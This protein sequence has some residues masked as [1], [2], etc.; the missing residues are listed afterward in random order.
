MNGPRPA[1]VAGCERLRTKVTEQLAL[2]PLVATSHP[3]V[4]PRPNLTHHQTQPIDLQAGG[5]SRQPGETP[6]GNNVA[7]AAW[8][9]RPGCRCGGTQPASTQ[10]VPCM[11]SFVP[12]SLL[13]CYCAIGRYPPLDCGLGP[14]PSLGHSL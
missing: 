5:S 6:A 11:P 7:V 13:P 3:C 12:G 1:A 14:R 10:N 8:K 9:T 4:H 2:C